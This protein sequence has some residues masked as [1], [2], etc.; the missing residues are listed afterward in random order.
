MNRRLLLVLGAVA[1]LVWLAGCASLL[2]SGQPDP[3]QL[4]ED[5]TY[6]WDTEARTTFN[7]SKT[8]FQTVMTVTNK[9]WVVVYQRD[10]VGTDEPLDISAL[11]FQY[12][13]G[14]VVDANQ[15]NLGARNEGQRTN[16]TLPQENGT[17]AFTAPRPNAKRFATPVFVEGSHEV[18]LPPRA[19]V[20]IPLLSQVAPSATWTNV[21]EDRMS[22]YWDDVERGPIVVRYY[23]QRDILLFGTLG[24]VLGLVGIVGALYYF[25]QIRVL[26]RQREEIWLDV[27]MEDD[28][29][30]RD[31]G[32]PPGMR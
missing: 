19:R 6:D 24:G 2:G 3:D 5:A 9:S 16:I 22:V 30:F 4:S 26:E 29:D 14:T 21:T 13:N 15:T 20:G 11:K 25:R 18:V 1:L 7:V 27:E 23:L 10:E 31:D 32:P 28:D 8:Q 12:T 17:V